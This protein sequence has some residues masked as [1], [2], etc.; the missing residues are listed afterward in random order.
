MNTS[1]RREMN[2]GVGGGRL[3]VW[4]DHFTIIKQTLPRLSHLLGFISSSL[5]CCWLLTACRVLS[6]CGERNAPERA[7]HKSNEYRG[8]K[9][10]DNQEK[11][12]ITLKALGLCGVA[13]AKPLPECRPPPFS[14]I[15]RSRVFATSIYS[16]YFHYAR[17][18][19]TCLPILSV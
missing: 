5:C 18:W 19:Q 11:H 16:F 9:Q 1:R 12:K 3:G 4:M 15:A 2:D 6:F 17:F 8:K 13:K 7:C 10:T 14:I